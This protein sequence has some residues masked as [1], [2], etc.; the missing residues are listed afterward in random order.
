MIRLL[1]PPILFLTL[2]CYALPLIA[3]QKPLEEISVHDLR[4]AI[5]ESLDATK[6]PARLQDVDL[7]PA[8]LTYESGKLR[9]VVHTPVN[10]GE[11]EL[12]EIDAAARQFLKDAARRAGLLTSADLARFDLIVDEAEILTPAKSRPQDELQDD[13][14]RVRPQ[15]REGVQAETDCRG[16]PLQIECPVEWHS[17]PCD[18][19]CTTYG[20]PSTCGT[21]TVSDAI[22]VAAQRHLQTPSVQ[23]VAKSTPTGQV[24]STTTGRTEVPDKLDEFAATAAFGLGCHAYWRGDYQNA[25]TDFN[26]AVRLF[27]QDARFW[28]FKGLTET[29]LGESSASDSFGLAVAL[30]AQGKPD[31]SVVSAALERV[32]GRMRLRLQAA[33]RQAQLFLLKRSPAPDD[34][35]GGVA[36]RVVAD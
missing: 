32:Q 15:P 13:S 10:S 8:R 21:R 7:S 31:S 30:E 19:W 18:C 6:R 24:V 12:T 3:Q 33:K 11:K 26:H 5:Q 16:I 17:S 14:R 35:L 27:D 28:Y 34:S 1:T 23:I 29:A 20:R 4:T 9:W 22:I 25:L 36:S 2:S